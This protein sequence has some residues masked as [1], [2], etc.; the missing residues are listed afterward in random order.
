[1]LNNSYDLVL[2]D[3]M[4]P[5]ISGLDMLNEIKQISPTTK[6]ILMTAYSTD[7]KIEKSKLL[8]A[9]GYIEKPFKSLKFVEE[10]IKSTLQK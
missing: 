1:M 6:V 3:I 8:N 4:M 5:L 9:D 10:V 7:K 2:T